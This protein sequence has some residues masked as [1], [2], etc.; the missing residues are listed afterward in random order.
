MTDLRARIG[1]IVAERYRLERPLGEGAAAIVFLAHDLK[2]DRDVALKILRPEVALVIGADRF[3]REISLSARLSHPHIVPLLDAGEWDGLLY[4]AMPVL[5]GASL[6]DRLNQ[7]G[8]LALDEALQ[9]VR[10][11]AVAIDYAHSRG[12]VHR[13]IKPENVLIGGGTATVADFGVAKIVDDGLSA[14]SITQS[15]LALG[16]VVYMSPEQASAGA[17]DGRSDLYSLGCMTYE[18]LAGEPP[19]TGPNSQAILA[20]HFTDAV[21]S[22]RRLRPALPPAI[23]DVLATAMAKAPADRFPT[24]AEFAAA[25]SR[26]RESAAA[27]GG[28]PT[29]PP[30]SKPRGP[31]GAAR[32]WVSRPAVAVAIAL[33][34]I[35]PVIFA[36]GGRGTNSDT[37]V[38]RDSLQSIA[39]LPFEDVSA[40]KDQEY[41][42]TGMADELITALS[43]LPRLRIAARTSSFALRGS[44]LSPREIGQ[45]LRVS[46]LLTGSIRRDGDRLRVNAELIDI[47]ADTVVWKDVFDRQMRDVFTV[48]EQIAQTIASRFR[49]LTTEKPLVS[50]ATGDLEAY[51][52]YLR[53]RLEW[54]KR[55]AA[56]LGSAV[57]F[58]TQ[59]TRLDPRYARAWAGLADTYNVIG[60]NFYG[61]P[62]ENFRAGREAARRAIALDSTLA[63]AHAALA[64]A[65]AFLDRDWESAEAS[66]RRAIRLDPTYPATYY[67][68]SIFLVNLHRFDEGLANAMT[69]RELDP[70]SAAM[71]QGVGMA[72][73]YSGRFEEA[74]EP[75]RR[76]ISL[77]P[78]YYFPHA[79]YAIALARRQQRD[80]ALAEARDAVRLAP[81]N[82]LVRTFLG[83]T[84]A[85]VGESD[86]ALA[87]AR[88]IEALQ[89][90]RAVPWVMLG[91]L[92]A[93]LGDKEQ[94]L[95]ALRRGM[96][97]NEAQLAQLRV[98]GF[99]ALHGDPR[100]EAM[101]K[102]LRLK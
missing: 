90:R 11:V 6:R 3:E 73:V 25:L 18:M 66:Y 54:N 99:E 94:A 8:P 10:D 59:A 41:F 21:P 60:L 44:N 62:G 1:T 84:F 32:S 63:E 97:A 36:W 86:S 39:V 43:R 40:A 64:S 71:A 45:R 51:S 85:L 26:V 27:S 80:S 93:I 69:A 22:V 76:A 91:R 47:G 35:V 95:Q 42:A 7:I 52:L 12:I 89:S 15:G 38:V 29:T 49:L 78:G 61:P 65:T 34:V 77:Q 37:E 57:D 58:F 46:S 87:V 96:E 83:Q 74:I 4:Y 9:I 23:D 70:A 53:G 50:V 82:V 13:D 55:T 100:Y 68:Y 19:F 5:S 16:T 56:S 101:L 24:C 92:Y 88:G 72:Y 75:L 31:G 67:F 17:I 20:K 33:A 98:P 81:E 79:W 48:Q 30:A 14:A 102:E 2:H 28:M